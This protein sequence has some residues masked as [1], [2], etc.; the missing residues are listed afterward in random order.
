MTTQITF[1]TDGTAR[2]VGESLLSGSVGKVLG[3]KRASKIEPHNWFLRGVFRVIRFA[4]EDDSVAAQWTRNW[5]C[6]WQVSI[7]GGPTLP[8]LYRDRMKAI[9][10][11]IAW[12]NENSL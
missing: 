9:S 4:F 8:K 7:V 5:P 6:L 10:D 11:E 1:G 3:T 12:L 2:H